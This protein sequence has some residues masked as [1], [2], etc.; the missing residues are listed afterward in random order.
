MEDEEQL[1]DL[2][3]VEEYTLPTGEKRFRFRI[4]G[5]SIYINVSADSR[6]EARRKALSLAREVGL[7]ELLKEI[8]KRQPS[9]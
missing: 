8:A 4:K 2:E 1:L 9:A 5:S 7:D 3:F 6:D